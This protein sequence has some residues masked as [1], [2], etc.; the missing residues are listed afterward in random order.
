MS[1][2]QGHIKRPMNSFM[3]WS[4]EKR[5]E[6]LKSNPGMSN[7]VISKKLGSTW[8]SLTEEEKRPY[9]EEAERLTSQH[10]QD[11]PDYKYRP[12]RHGKNKNKS[13]VAIGGSRSP[14]PPII[15]GKTELSF[16]PEWSLS[17][18]KAG[19]FAATKSPSMIP[20]TGFQQ[21]AAHRPSLSRPSPLFLAE[22]DP[23]A[24][25]FMTYPT[26][27]PYSPRLYSSPT[28]LGPQNHP[29]VCMGDV[30]TPF[31]HIAASDATLPPPYKG[32]FHTAPEKWTFAYPSPVETAR[33]VFNGQVR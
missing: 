22:N 31:R 8:R 29:F 6:I 21:H 12:R 33:Y 2:R 5:C 18:S 26:Y 13:A 9:V 19:A 17:P 20:P 10:K 25:Y 3:V 32:E 23:S 7:A 11:Y 15:C 16:T 30:F 4:R 1:A 24:R 27:P 14:C 28:H